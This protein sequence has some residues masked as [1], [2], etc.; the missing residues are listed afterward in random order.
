MQFQKVAQ[1][2][3]LADGEKRK[4]TLDGKV[5]L[6]TKIGGTCYAIDNRCPH[7][8]G[9]LYDG[10]LD[11]TSIRCPRH[12]TAF[13]VRTGEVI[14]NGKLAFVKLNVHAVNTYPIRVEQGDVLV[15]LA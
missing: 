15:G 6:L 10:K 1:F 11:G 14:A 2:D 5:I 9:S 7:M 13:D 8:G 12:G 4:I 3:E